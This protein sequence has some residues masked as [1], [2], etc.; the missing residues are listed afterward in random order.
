MIIWIFFSYWN[1][2][3]L[4]IFDSAIL[5]TTQKNSLLNLIGFET[6]K[7][8]LLWRATR[9]GFQAAKFHSLCDGK[10]NTLTVIK[11]TTGYIFGGY[12]SL[13]WDSSSGHRND[14]TA[15]MFTLTNPSNTPLKIQQISPTSSYSVYSGSSDGPCFGGGRDL[16]VADMSNT[17]DNYCSLLSYKLPNGLT[18]LAGGKWIYGGTTDYFKATEVEVF[19]VIWYIY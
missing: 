14:P 1:S 11:S 9:D 8:P 10:A 2:I 18:G 3:C 16:R 17:Y 19:L 4:P 13:A 7:F 6:K 5:S 12:A 15:F